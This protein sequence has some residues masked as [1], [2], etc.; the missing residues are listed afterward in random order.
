MSAPAVVL[1]SLLRAA[2]LFFWTLVLWGALLLLPFLLDVA[3]E[4]FRPALGRL[5]PARGDSV[6]AWVNAGS[7][8]LALAVGA[9]VGGRLAWG[10]RARSASRT[11]AAGEL[12]FGPPREGP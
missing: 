10:K 2:A 1:R 3:G 6:W 7:V 12:R 8:A 11:R 9:A 4:G 5:L